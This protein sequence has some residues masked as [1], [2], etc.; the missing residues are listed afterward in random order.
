[1]LFRTEDMSL[2]S[3]LDDYRDCFSKPQFRHFKTFMSGLMLNG[4]NE[5][6]IMDISNSAAGIGKVMK[7]RSFRKTFLTLS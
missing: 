4:K 3:T 7:G 6:N 1:M 2:A 5:K